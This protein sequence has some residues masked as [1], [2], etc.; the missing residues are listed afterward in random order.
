MLDGDKMSYAV[1]M[2]DGEMPASSEANTLF[3]ETIGRPM[4]LIP[5]AG[6]HLRTRR[7]R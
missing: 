7:R 1:E 5:V 6:V 3:I 4:T 2:L